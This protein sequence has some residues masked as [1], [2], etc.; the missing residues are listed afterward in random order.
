MLSLESSSMGSSTETSRAM[1]WP[2]LL[3]GSSGFRCTSNVNWVP[4]WR[5]SGLSSLVV[6]VVVLLLLGWESMVHFR[7]KRFQVGS[8][9]ER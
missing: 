1:A 3:S 7:Q 5:L 4:R 6:V 2:G 9:D 8:W